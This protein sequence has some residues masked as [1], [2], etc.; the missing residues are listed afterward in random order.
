MTTTWSRSPWLALCPPDVVEL[1]APDA[2]RVRRE[3]PGTP[4]ALVTDRPFSRRRL[5]RVARQ[6]GVTIERELVA[7]PTTRFVVALADDNEAAVRHL[8]RNVVTVP[9]GM[10]ASPLPA[11]LA[12]RVL[13]RLPWTATGAL[14]PGRVVI[15]RRT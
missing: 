9:S 15:G 5:R 10:V 14:A 4:V 12:L 11:A 8:W 3:P 2:Q 7:L 13:R 1:R 6:S